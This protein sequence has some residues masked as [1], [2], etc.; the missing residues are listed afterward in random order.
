MHDSSDFAAARL[1][2]LLQLLDIPT[3]RR[4]LDKPS[5]LRW[6]QRNVSIDNG[7]AD[8]LDT[9][10]LLIRTLIRRGHK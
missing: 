8:S 2:E 4:D 9:I 5:N 6:L 3:M 10:H 7:D 1:T